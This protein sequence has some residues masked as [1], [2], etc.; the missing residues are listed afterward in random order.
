M[1]NSYLGLWNTIW[2]T[3]NSK[4]TDRLQK[5]PVPFLIMEPKSYGCDA[6]QN[7]L[8]EQRAQKGERAHYHMAGKQVAEQTDGQRNQPQEGREHLD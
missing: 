8:E 3:I 5:L 7:R 1:N 6:L 4:G 2:G